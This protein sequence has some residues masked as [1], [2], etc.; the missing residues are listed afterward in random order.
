[1]PGTRRLLQNDCLEARSGRSL[2]HIEANLR[3]VSVRHWL[4]DNLTCESQRAK[5]WHRAPARNRPKR[6]SPSSFPHKRRFGRF[7]TSLASQND[8][9]TTAGISPSPKSGS[10]NSAA[11]PGWRM[12]NEQ[13]CGG[14]PSARSAEDCHASGASTREHQWRPKP[15][16]GAGFPP[17]SRNVYDAPTNLT[18]L[19]GSGR[20][21]CISPC[22]RTYLRCSTLRSRGRSC[23]A[24]FSPWVTRIAGTA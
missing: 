13:L 15:F 11:L 10:A 4:V 12:R 23:R 17:V 8:V 18:G 7:P 5:R 24:R 19:E 22:V 21:T 2:E 3:A 16:A 14:G 9:C 20:S 6:Y 1:M